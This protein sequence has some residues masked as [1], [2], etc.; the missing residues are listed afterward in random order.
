MIRYP[1]VAGEFYPAG[2]DELLKT[3]KESFKSNFGPGKFPEKGCRKKLNV[4]IVPHAGY[5]FSGPC[6][7][8]GYKALAESGKVETFVIIGTNHSG[9]GENV[10]VFNEGEWITPLGKVTIDEDFAAELLK[11]N[12]EISANFAAHEKEHS[13]EV[14]IPFLQ[15]LFKNFKIVPILIKGDNLNESC[16]FLAKVIAETSKKLKRKIKVII[17]SDFTHYGPYYSYIPFKA[18][19]KEEVKNLDK[20][21]IDYIIKNNPEKFVEHLIKFNA[22]ICGYAPILTGIYYNKI[23]D[24]KTGTLLKYYTSADI[25]NNSENFVGYASIILK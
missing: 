21:A 18:N 5:I 24:G 23:L 10:S 6:A 25:S 22:T 16:K 1:F 12:K 11:D 19:A 15:V 7:A 14:Q 4:V 13:I 17:S 9:L 2:S 8:H 3:I 20:I